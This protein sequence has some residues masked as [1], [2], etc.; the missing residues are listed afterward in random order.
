[1]TTTAEVI[2]RTR[3]VRRWTQQQM[4]EAIGVT[5]TQVANVEAGRTDL[6]AQRLLVLLDYVGVTVMPP[7]PPPLIND[8]DMFGLKRCEHCDADT[9]QAPA[10][11]TCL[12]CI[13]DGGTCCSLRFYNRWVTPEA[14][15]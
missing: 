12:Q 14:A 6:P 9:V 8:P 4:A 11:D 13:A 15:S 3:R 1:M 5:R 10:A 7:A 2:S